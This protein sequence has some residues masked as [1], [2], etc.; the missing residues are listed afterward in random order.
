MRSFLSGKPYLRLLRI[1]NALI[2]PFNLEMSALF[3][4]IGKLKNRHNAYACS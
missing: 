4:G 2:S 1:A 3:F